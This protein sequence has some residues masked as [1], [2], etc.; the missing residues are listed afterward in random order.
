[1]EEARYISVVTYRKRVSAG[2]SSWHANDE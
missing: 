1:V 2:T